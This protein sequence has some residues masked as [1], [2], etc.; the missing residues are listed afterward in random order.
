M[1]RTKTKKVYNET[2]VKGTYV[3]SKDDLINLIN[4]DKVSVYIAERSKY[5]DGSEE[6]KLVIIHQ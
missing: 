4:K 6:L 5:S 3:P 2:Y 1:A